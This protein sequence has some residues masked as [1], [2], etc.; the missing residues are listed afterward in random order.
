MKKYVIYVS[1]L[2]CIG[3][4][5]CSEEDGLTAETDPRASY[6]MPAESAMDEESVLRRDFFKEEN[7]YL[8]FHDT[9]AKEPLG[10]DYNGEMRYR[11]ETIDLA[12]IL[13]AS[14]HSSSSGYEFEF[15][16]SIEEKRAGVDFVKSELLSH[17]SLS[18]RPFSWLLAK[19]VV[20]VD[21]RGPVEHKIV[22]GES[23]TALALGDILS[24]SAEEKRALGDEVRISALTH[25][26][27]GKSDALKNFYAL[28]DGFYG[29]WFFSEYDGTEEGNRAY[30]LEHGFICKG[31]SLWTGT[32]VNG[33][34]PDKERDCGA[35]IRLVLDHTDAEVEEM[36]ERSPLVLKKYYIM[37]D[38][39][40][41]LGYIK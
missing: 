40:D 25:A 12:Y 13:G 2:F 32:E 15:L 41:E 10:V 3:M 24:L 37:K 38:L 4:G 18:L 9:L 16:P 22:C 20:F 28:S 6:Y 5:A 23:C 33:T 36:Y 35:Y 39:I 19:K 30:L 31:V 8:L 11:I 21:W 29:R 27:A 7:S 34:S 26:M 14:V 17:F 1:A